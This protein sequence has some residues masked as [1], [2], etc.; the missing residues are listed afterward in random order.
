MLD[1]LK[2]NK[3]AEVAPLVVSPIF[4]TAPKERQILEGYICNFMQC[5]SIKTSFLYKY[6]E[7]NKNFSNYL[8]LKEAYDFVIV[9]RTKKSQIFGVI[10][11]GIGAKSKAMAFNLNSAKCFTGD[12]NIPSSTFDGGY[13]IFGQGEIRFRSNSNL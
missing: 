5:K 10:S 7:F 13:L 9:A 3:K 8:P 11:C 1:Y 2:N 6:D 12:A 4:E